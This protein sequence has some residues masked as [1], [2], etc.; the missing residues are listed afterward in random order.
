MKPGDI[1]HSRVTFSWGTARLPSA[2][3]SAR[4]EVSE[5]IPRNVEKSNRQ[6]R[7]GFRRKIWVPG[8]IWRDYFSKD[9][10]HSNIKTIKKRKREKKRKKERYCSS[11][12]KTSWLQWMSNLTPT[13][14]NWEYATQSIGSPQNLRLGHTF[15]AELHSKYA[16]NTSPLTMEE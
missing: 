6:H 11:A 1:P 7:W 5:I 2:V 10:H 15:A 4:L 13:F 8:L 12:T 16:A 9:T 14:L 3:S